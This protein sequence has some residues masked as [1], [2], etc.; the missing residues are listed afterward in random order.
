M[1]TQT[2]LKIV[3]TKEKN[4]KRQENFLQ[5]AVYMKCN[6]EIKLTLIEGDD[7]MTSIC[8]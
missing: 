6:K 5:I 2:V 7:I 1:M 8:K 4:Y 3:N